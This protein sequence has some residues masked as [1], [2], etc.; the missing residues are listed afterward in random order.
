MGERR[1]SLYTA[2]QSVGEGWKKSSM[3]ATT[4][5]HIP[6]HAGMNPKMVWN[7]RLSRF[8]TIGKFYF[9]T[10][11]A[12]EA[13]PLVLL[14]IFDVLKFFINKNVLKIKITNNK[15]DSS[16]SDKLKFK[17]SIHTIIRWLSEAQQIVLNLCEWH[18]I[19][20]TFYVVDQ[21]RFNQLKP[22]ALIR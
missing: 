1:N 18:P 4:T 6:R 21:R 16:Y 14:T 11:S 15:H 19:W 22:R 9:N 17:I 12:L 20:R 13:P 10:C 3:D 2:K 7:H 8:E 5:R